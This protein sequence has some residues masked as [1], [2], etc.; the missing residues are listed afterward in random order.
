MTRVLV[1]GGTGTLGRQAVAALERGGA[2]TVR[3]LT[4][5]ER[6]ADAPPQREWCVADLRSDPLDAAVR[7]VD[8]VLHLASAK[9]EEDV[10]AAQR[11]LCA[12]SPWTR[13]R[14]RHAWPRSRSGRRWAS[15]RRS[16]APRC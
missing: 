7:D 3:L 14:P 12:S 6:P 8:A 5:R 2:S 10:P 11:L 16:R 1:T 15:R 13:A 4:R 9:G